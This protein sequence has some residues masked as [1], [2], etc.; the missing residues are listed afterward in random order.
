MLGASKGLLC[1]VNRLSW[2]NTICS[3]YGSHA[4]STLIAPL[5]ERRSASLAGEMLQKPRRGTILRWTRSEGRPLTA[6]NL[7]ATYVARR[8]ASW[9]EQEGRV[10]ECARDGFH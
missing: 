10:A 8:R 9:V 5:P 1:G 3:E 4:V 7:Q 6:E 2:R